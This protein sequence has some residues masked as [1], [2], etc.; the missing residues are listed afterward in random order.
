M[1]SYFIIIINKINKVY[2]TKLLL[3]NMIN[4]YWTVGVKGGSEI[5]HCIIHDQDQLIK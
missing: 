2:S 1:S 5:A 3:Y 4:D